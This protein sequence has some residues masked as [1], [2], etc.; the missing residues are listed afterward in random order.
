MYTQTV[1]DMTIKIGMS[2]HHDIEHTEIQEN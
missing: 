2:T 1:R